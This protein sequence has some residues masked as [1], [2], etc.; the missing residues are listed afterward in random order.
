MRSPSKARPL[1]QVISQK[2]EN[3]YFFAAGPASANF[4]LR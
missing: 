2:T 4:S 3:R 1:L